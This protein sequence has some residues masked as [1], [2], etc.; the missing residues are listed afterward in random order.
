MPQL[1]CFI[2]HD[3][4]SP[5]IAV[6][7]QCADRHLQHIIRLPNDD[8]SGDSVAL[9]EGLPF[10]RLIHELEKN[11]GPLLLDSKGRYLGVSERLDA[12]HLCVELPATP[13]VKYG[14]RT[15]AYFDCIFAQHLQHDFK[16]SHVADFH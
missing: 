6:S 16:V 2:R 8:M 10:S 4:G 12:S 14:R 1:R 15:L 7:K 3:V 5:A 13:A 9:S 11:S